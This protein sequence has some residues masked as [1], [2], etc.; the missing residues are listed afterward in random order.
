KHLDL[1]GNALW[2]LTMVSDI[3]RGGQQVPVEIWP[4][5]PA[6]LKPIPGRFQLVRAYQ[7]TDSETREIPAENVLHF[8]FQ[9]PANH[10]WGMPPLMATARA[11]DTSVEILRWNKIALQNRGM[12]DGVYT[13]AQPL[14]REDWEMARRE[15]LNA[16]NSP[17]NAR[18]PLVLGAGADFKVVSWKP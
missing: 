10:Y 13:F 14:S 18:V 11:V 2:S 12:P 4:L 17:D 8:K 15:I 5:D 9:D 16:Y 1:A 6:R 7:Y 3:R